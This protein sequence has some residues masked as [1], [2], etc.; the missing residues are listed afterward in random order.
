MYNA[1]LRRDH[2]QARSVLPGWAARI[3][4]PNVPMSA[5]ELKYYA[6]LNYGHW[7]TGTR[8]A[9]ESL[10]VLPSIQAKANH[11][12]V[13]AAITPGDFALLHREHMSSQHR[14]PN[15]GRTDPPNML[16]K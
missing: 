3:Y 11:L 9:I 5:F 8:A 7:L 4:V 14:K 1:I 15:W 10:C 2:E 12:K 13:G 6:I 16:Q